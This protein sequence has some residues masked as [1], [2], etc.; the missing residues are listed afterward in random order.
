VLSPKHAITRPIP[1]DNVSTCCEIVTAQP[2]GNSR[3]VCDVECGDKA[4]HGGNDD[5]HPR[6]P[7]TPTGRRLR[8]SLLLL[9]RSAVVRLL[10]CDQGG[11]PPHRFAVE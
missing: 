10:S 4:D 7:P 6:K 1:I 11:E 3:R 8:R 9:H 2:A 5:E